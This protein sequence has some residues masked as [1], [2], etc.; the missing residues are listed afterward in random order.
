MLSV[1]NSSSKALTYTRCLIFQTVLFLVMPSSQPP[2]SFRL[3]KLGNVKGRGNGTADGWEGVTFTFL[4]GYLRYA[5]T[6]LDGADMYVCPQP[7]GMK[8]IFLCSIAIW[9]K[10]LRLLC[11]VTSPRLFSGPPEK[12]HSE[13]S[14]HPASKSPSRCRSVPRRIFPARHVKERRKFHTASCSI[15][16]RQ[17]VTFSEPIFPSSTRNTHKK[18]ENVSTYLG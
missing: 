14:F 17:A 18:E 4:Y 10:N 2:R 1:C 11:S 16:A 8:N 7:N 5:P 12:W 3:E 6:H 13:R 9:K 15:A